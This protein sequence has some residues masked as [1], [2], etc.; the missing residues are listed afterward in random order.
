[1]ARFIGVIAHDVSLIIVIVSTSTPNLFKRGCGV[2]ILGIA[3]LAAPTGLLAQ[4]GGGGG[5]GGGGGIGAGGGG[6]GGTTG[7]G[8]RNTTPLICV[9]DCPSLREGLNATDD[10]KDF[11]RAMAVQA[12]AEQRAA[13]AKVAQYAQ[14]ASVELQKF[15][16]SLQQS[17]ASTAL[18]DRTTS[19]DAAIENALA[20]NKNFLTSLSAKQK[21]GLQDATKKLERA[22]FELDRQMKAL[23]QIVHTPKPESEAIAGSAATLDK[24]LENFQSEQLALG[25]EMSILFD[26]AGQVAFSLP[27]VTNSIDFGGQTISMPTSGAVSRASVGTSA[28]TPA[29]ASA[30]TSGGSGPDNLFNLKLV[31]DLSDVQQSVT[32]ILRSQLTRSPRCGERI[33]V[34]KATFT[35]LIPAGLVVADLHIE[36]WV[37]APGQQGP[38]E[39]AAGEASMDVKL[40]PSL[41]ANGD[42]ALVS[43]IARV[44]A[45]GLLRNQ[46]RSGDLGV[47]LR[48]EIAASV[49][50]AL[51]KG[52]DLKTTLP[53]VAQQSATLQKVQFQDEGADQLS[54]VLDG[55]LQFS[56]EQ[57]Q[58]FA[59]QLKQRLTASGTTPQ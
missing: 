19:L 38:M 59:A 7:S 37:C 3:L 52:V 50:S 22:D 51:R 46:L 45:E 13:F 39:V 32:S 28:A 2:L 17:A 56:D 41:E 4:R 16:K 20:G 40:T 15:R 6:M 18:A 29:G 57:A 35:P 44:Q 53:P 11:R 10:L 5:G 58:Q 1:M 34:Q 47:M 27:A 48:D 30:A 54:L 42:M 33:E 9:H 49:L 8:G 24:V 36:R 21:S 55:Q 43:E 12:T 26:P 14:A 23:D 31:A 25:G